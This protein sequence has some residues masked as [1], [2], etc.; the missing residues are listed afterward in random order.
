[1]GTISRCVRQLQHSLRMT[2][3]VPSHHS[4][5]TIRPFTI[6]S[7]KLSHTRVKPVFPRVV[8]QHTGLSQ[9]H[10]SGSAAQDTLLAKR[11][12]DAFYTRRFS[13]QTTLSR[14]VYAQLHILATWFLVSGYGASI[15]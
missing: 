8:V 5:A 2:E 10:G 12:H 13:S 3:L 4:T 7:L 14:V 1:M 6:T 9:N 15:W 11:N